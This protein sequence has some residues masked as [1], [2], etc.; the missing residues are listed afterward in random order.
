M[1]DVS[2]RRPR[3]TARSAPT[4]RPASPPLA[5]YGI[6]EQVLTGWIFD[7]APIPV[8]EI[9]EAKDLVVAAIVDG[10]AAPASTRAV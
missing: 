1:G 2:R 10:L 3:R 7:P 9:E 8:E 5:F 6:I 4:S